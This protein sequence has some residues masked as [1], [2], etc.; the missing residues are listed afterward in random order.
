MFIPPL[1]S[2]VSPVRNE[3]SD[4]GEERDDRARLPPGV[5]ARPSST[6]LAAFSN[7]S[8]A[9]KRPW[10]AVSPIRPGRHAVDADA[11]RRQLFGQRLRQRR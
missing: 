6:L 8:G 1:I 3:L 10:N 11:V 4:D 5:P 7:A 9:V 2:I